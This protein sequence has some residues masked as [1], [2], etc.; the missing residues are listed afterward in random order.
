MAKKNLFAQKIDPLVIN[1]INSYK[2]TFT[3]PQVL[4]KVLQNASVAKLMRQAY[5]ID[6]FWDINL[7]VKRAVMDRINVELRRRK[8]SPALG[9]SLRIYENYAL[10]SGQPHRWQK[11]EVMAL[12]ELQL[13]LDWRIRNT[14][15]P[16]QTIADAY[17][18]LIGIMIEGEYETVGDALSA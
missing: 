1:A 9:V 3:K 8:K 6:P 12:A 16:N 5:Q 11:F 7:V 2:R 17:Q 18:K 13:C 10:V 15:R 4:D 14:I